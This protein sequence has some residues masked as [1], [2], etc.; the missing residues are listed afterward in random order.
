MK[1]FIE[2]AS[3][4][5]VDPDWTE[6]R[7][8]LGIAYL[9]TGDSENAVRE[10]QEVLKRDPRSLTAYA[11]LSCS[12]LQV[13]KFAD[14]ENAARLA[15]EIDSTSQAS[16]FY[17]GV[18]LALQG[19]D[20]GQ[21]LQYLRKVSGDFLSF[22]GRSRRQMASQ[23]LAIAIKLSRLVPESGGSGL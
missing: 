11:G 14:A 22:L 1:G 3:K 2:H 13:D 20:D 19:K 18:S 8:N 6:A 4:A 15:L 23:E 10:F 12:Y 7:R 17:L 5:I 9:V 21:A 16:R